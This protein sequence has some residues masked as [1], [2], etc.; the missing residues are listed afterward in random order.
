MTSQP[1]QENPRTLRPAHTQGSV[2]RWEGRSI[3]LWEIRL[4]KDSNSGHG[5]ATPE[6]WPIGIGP[7]KKSPRKLEIGQSVMFGTLVAS[8]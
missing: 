5:D 2:T 7:N 6:A 4:T 3:Y 1:A 8:R